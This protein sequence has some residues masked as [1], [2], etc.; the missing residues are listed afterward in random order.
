MCV[1]S[2]R[3]FGVAGELPGGAELPRVDEV[4]DRPQIAEAVLD[5]GAGQS[6]AGLGL[7]RL[8]RP[9]LLGMRV[10]D[11]LRLVENDQPPVDLGEHG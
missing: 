1:R 4:E 3:L 5:R 2:A 11:R 8:G 10:P 6:D 7:Q 9:C